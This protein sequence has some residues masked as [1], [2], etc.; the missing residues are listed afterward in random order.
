MRGTEIAQNIF[1]RVASFLSADDDDAM[2]AQSR[3]TADHRAVIGEQAVAVEFLKIGERLADVIQRVRTFWMARE[4]DAL[5]RRKIQKNL[6][7]GFFQLAFDKLDFFL[8]TDAER[9]F[10]GMLAE[11]VQ[12]GL[13]FDDGLL[14]IELMFHALGRLIVFCVPINADFQPVIH[15]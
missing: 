10:F 7:S 9:M 11:F 4:L 5:P 15:N 14:E 1:L 13:Q 8:E 3:K 6:P 12:L 2:F